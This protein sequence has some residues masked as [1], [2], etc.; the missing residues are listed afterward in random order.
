MRVLIMGAGAVG[1]YY[2]AR[3]AQAGH[4]VAFVARGAHAEAMRQ[5]GLTIRVGDDAAVLAPVT[6]LDAP[7]AAGGAPDLALLTVKGYDAEAAIAALQPAVG[8]GTTVLT[9]L[10]GVDAADQLAAAFGPERVLAGTTTINVA[11][12][13]PGVILERGV[14]IRTIIAE[15]SGALTPRLETIAAA[16]AA[17]PGEAVVSDDPRVTL[18]RKFVLLAPHGT[19]TAATGLPVGPIRE[20][21]EGAALY[22]QLIHEAVAVG[23][24]S[25]AALPAE[26]ADATIDFVMNSLPPTAVSSL[27]ADFERRRRVELEQITGAIVRR[28]RTFGVPTPG[29]EPLYAV[30]KARAL[31]FGGLS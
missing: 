23:R 19:I 16:L 8:P 26:I 12:V 1:S 9:L 18:W 21:P 25:G 3:L 31:A 6:V 14:P 27:A 4:E 11:L 17:I 13:E 7:A 24:A 15:L 28:G 22:R 2:G 5:R 30:L 29:F 20:T 10:N